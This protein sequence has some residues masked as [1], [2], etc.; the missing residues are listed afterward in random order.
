MKGERCLLEPDLTDNRQELCLG[1]VM[2]QLK[3][4]VR[5][6]AGGP[7]G[8]VGLGE[9][10]RLLRQKR[11]TLTGARPSPTKDPVCLKPASASQEKDQRNVEAM[12]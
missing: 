7:K 3:S 9:V 4:R 11:R 6:T 1:S 10:S 2:L 8:P 5:V 12:T